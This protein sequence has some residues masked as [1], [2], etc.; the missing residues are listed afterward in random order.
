[1]VY[2]KIAMFKEPHSTFPLVH[3]AIRYKERNP[4]FADD[5]VVSRVSSGADDR[6]CTFGPFPVSV[7][8][9][10]GFWKNVFIISCPRRRGTGTKGPSFPAWT[11]HAGKRVGPVRFVSRARERIINVNVLWSRTLP[12]E[13]LARARDTRRASAVSVHRP[14]SG[15]RPDRV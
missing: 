9:A 1:M 10:R 8:F 11:T 15:S 2:R 6:R 3:V 5:R 4:S 12:R 7:A 13:G 14:N